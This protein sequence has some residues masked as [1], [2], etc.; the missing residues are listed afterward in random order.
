M[1]MDIFPFLLLSV[2]ELLKKDNLICAQ[3]IQ[4][5]IQEDDAFGVRPPLADCRLAL[6]LM[7]NSGFIIKYNNFGIYAKGNNENRR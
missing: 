7:E 5:F 1:A 2:G 4:D 3:D 6:Q